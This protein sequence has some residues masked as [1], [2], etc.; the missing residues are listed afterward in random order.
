M[1]NITNRQLELLRQ[2]AEAQRAVP[3]GQHVDFLTATTFDGAEIISPVGES[4]PL[5]RQDLDELIDHGLIRTTK[6]RKHGDVNGHVTNNGFSFLENADSD[7][8]AERNASPLF[9]NPRDIPTVFISYSHE[10][11]AHKNWVRTSLAERLMASGIRVI[12]DQWHLKFGS[13]LPYFMENA[14][15]ADSVLLVCTPDFALRANSRQGGVGYESSIITAE[16]LDRR[17]SVEPKFVP[18]W[19]DGSRC[20]ATPHY[21]RSA[22]AVDLRDQ[23]PEYEQEFNKLLRQLHREPEHVPPPLGSKPDFESHER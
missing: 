20:A 22:L 9:E 10:S 2:L 6:F 19:R 12:L 5:N 11:N 8:E 17:P 1:V 13:D 14:S 4:C 3:N 18:V 7:P 16:I 23:N 15:R 21:L